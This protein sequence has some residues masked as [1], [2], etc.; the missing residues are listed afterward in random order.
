[1]NIACGSI[2][3][4]LEHHFIQENNQVSAHTFLPFHN[5]NAALDNGR[6]DADA[7]LSSTLREFERQAQRHLQLFRESVG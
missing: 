5:E 4:A 6:A 3:Q 2:E 1:M 7:A